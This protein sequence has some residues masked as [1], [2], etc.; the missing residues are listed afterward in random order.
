MTWQPLRP[1]TPHIKGV[2]IDIGDEEQFANDTYVVNRREVRAESP[3]APRC[4][5]LSIRR[6][7]REP[8]RD[9]RDFQRIK[10]Q[11]AG[12]EWTAVEIYPAE[13]KKVD[14]ANQYHLWAFDTDYLGFGFTKRLVTNQYQTS[15]ATPGAVQRDPEAI[16]LMYGGLSKLKDL[17]DDN[18]PYPTL[19]DQ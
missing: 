17:V 7:D 4:Y 16:D 18:P 1:S 14:G 3:N 6:Q 5:H 9:W 12:P 8:V 15:I 13:S 10:N 2:P 19:E 11:L